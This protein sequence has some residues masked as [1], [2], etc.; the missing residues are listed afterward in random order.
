MLWIDWGAIGRWAVVVVG[1]SLVTTIVVA[2]FLKGAG[3]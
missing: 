3:K 1:C 2:A